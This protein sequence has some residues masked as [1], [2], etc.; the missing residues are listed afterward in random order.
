M[1]PRVTRR[2]RACHDGLK[3]GRAEL[4]LPLFRHAAAQASP[5]ST[6]IAARGY[7]DVVAAMLL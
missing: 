2:A 7:Y 3:D 4:L 5:A 6:A 1:S